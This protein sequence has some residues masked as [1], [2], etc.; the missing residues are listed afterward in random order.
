M[1]KTTE[2]VKDFII[3]CLEEKKAEDITCIDLGEKVALAKYMIFASGRSIKNIGAIAEHISI[4][5][6][7]QANL[8]V[9]IEGLGNS[10]WVLID[11]GDIIV[12]IFHPEARNH[13]QLEEL[14]HKRVSKH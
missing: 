14:W 12:N 8:K 5:L 2:Q 6:K 4:E 9:N 10:N 7:H 1:I 3:D 11:I 13:F